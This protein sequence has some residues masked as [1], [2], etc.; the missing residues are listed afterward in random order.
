MEREDEGQRA[1]ATRKRDVIEE[2]SDTC[3]LMDLFARVLV[4]STPLCDLISTYT[5]LFLRFCEEE[6]RKELL[7]L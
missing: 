4:T 5:M 1:V 6:K 3:A 7:H 2:V